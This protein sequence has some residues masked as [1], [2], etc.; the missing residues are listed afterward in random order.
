MSWLVSSAATSIPSFESDDESDTVDEAPYIPLSLTF[1]IYPMKEE[2]AVLT[3]RPTAD[4][5]RHWLVDD[6]L[7]VSEL[8]VG[9]LKGF[10]DSEHT[11]QSDGRYSGLR[12]I[13]NQRR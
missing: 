3:E 5:T 11:E 9:Y 10:L 6:E 12:F 13:Q 1:P 4:P 8:H 7:R 2:T